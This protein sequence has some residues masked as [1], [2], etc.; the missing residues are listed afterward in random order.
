MGTILFLNECAL[1]CLNKHGFRKYMAVDLFFMIVS[2]CLFSAYFKSLFFRLFRLSS[3]HSITIHNLSSSSLPFG[4]S[5]STVSVRALYVFFS[6]CPVHTNCSTKLSDALMIIHNNLSNGYS[7]HNLSK[8][9][10]IH[11]A[12]PMV[13]G[14]LTNSHEMT[15]DIF[16]LLITFS[17]M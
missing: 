17:P 6:I 9:K 12:I 5:S 13:A 16:I 2:V 8:N 3:A 15:N 11:S 10:A 4:S 7:A 1:A 14:T